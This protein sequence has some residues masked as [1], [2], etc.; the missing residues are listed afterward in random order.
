MYEIY[1]LKK[2]EVPRRIH[3]SFFKEVGFIP[4]VSESV[5]ESD[6]PDYYIDTSFLDSLAQMSNKVVFHDGCVEFQDGFTQD[7]F[8]R[9]MYNIFD[10][11]PVICYDNIRRLIEDVR[12]VY[13][14]DIGFMTLPDFCRQANGVYYYG[15]VFEA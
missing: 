11:N 6:S 3:E 5:K 10:T 12:W 8:E 14:E 1:V 4:W 7:V 2:D 9:L 13:L 15:Q